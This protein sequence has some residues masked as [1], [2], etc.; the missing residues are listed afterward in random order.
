MVIVRVRAIAGG[1]HKQAAA[2]SG[3]SGNSKSKSGNSKSK[4]GNSKSK[5]NSAEGCI[6]KQ[7][8]CTATHKQH[9]GPPPEMGTA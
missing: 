2:T 3:N 6:N 1:L 9:Q 4:S 8:Q 7:P 5:S